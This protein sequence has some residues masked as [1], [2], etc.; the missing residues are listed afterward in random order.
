M[1]SVG[2][3]NISGAFWSRCVHALAC[4]GSPFF[5]NLQGSIQVFEY[6]VHV[7]ISLLMDIGVSSNFGL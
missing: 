1:G 7:F 4:I 6:M 3:H 5:S 2:E